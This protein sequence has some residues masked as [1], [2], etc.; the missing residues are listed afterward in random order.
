[1]PRMSEATARRRPPAETI[2]AAVFVKGEKKLQAA[3]ARD[4]FY[5]FRRLIRPEMKT[6][7]WTNCIEADLQR[8][9]SRVRGSGGDRCIHECCFLVWR[10]TLAPAAPFAW[11]RSSWHRYFPKALL[12]LIEP[13]TRHAALPGRRGPKPGFLHCQMTKYHDRC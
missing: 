5:W 6:N 7:W 2:S 10:T 12:G 8:F 4:S 3:R 11:F 1:M 9:Y 13:V